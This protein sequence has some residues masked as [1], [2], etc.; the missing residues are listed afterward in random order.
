MYICWSLD[1]PLPLPEDGTD[2]ALSSL[3]SRQVPPSPARFAVGICNLGSI[4][5]TSKTPFAKS[6]VDDPQTVP[7]LTSPPPKQSRVLSQC[8]PHSCTV[9]CVFRWL[10]VGIRP[11]D[12]HFRHRIDQAVILVV[13]ICQMDFWGKSYECFTFLGA[14]LLEF[15]LETIIMSTGSIRRFRWCFFLFEW[16]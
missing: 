3:K 13:F 16:P 8:R 10:F 12:H 9:F 14:Y 11:R 1:P 7:Q 15:Y 6:L 2:H 5:L 4:S